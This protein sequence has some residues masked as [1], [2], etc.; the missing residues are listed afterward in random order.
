MLQ[1]VVNVVNFR[2]DEKQ[3]N[4]VVH[5]DKD[6]PRTLIGDDQRIAQVITICSRM[7]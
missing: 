5:I 1:K 4:F 2:V 3:Q 6:I 7:P